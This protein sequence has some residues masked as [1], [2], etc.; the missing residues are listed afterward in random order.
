MPQ[1]SYLS[2]RPFLA[3]ILL[4][5]FCAVGR[6]VAQDPAQ[7]SY[8]GTLGASH[9]GLVLIVKGGNAITGGHYY[10]ARYYTDIPLTG[11]LQAGGLALKGQ[12]GGAFALKFIGNGS[13]GGKPLD[14]TNSVGLEGTWSKEGKSLAVKLNAGGESAVS[15]SGRWYDMVTDQSDATF[16]ARVQG[17]YKAAL[18]GD[19]TAIVKYVDFPLR[20]NQNGQSHTVKNAAE[21]AAEWEKIFTPAYI[22]ALKKDIPH[23]LGIVQGQ[24]MLGQGEAYF[25]SKGATALNLP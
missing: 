10:Y 1:R 14:F 4:I 9:I 8:D 3:G 13:N 17:F 7:I 15:T 2:N 16:E 20:I 22:A 6:A 21:L 25:G 5:V 18:A 24:A 23:D 19:R 12:D 11:S